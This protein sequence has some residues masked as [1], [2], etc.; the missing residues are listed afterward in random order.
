MFKPGDRYI[1]FTKYGS[2][3]FGTVKHVHEVNIID[4]ENRVVY[5]SV[6]IIT[7]KNNCLELDGSDG[8]IYRIVKDLSDDDVKAL[9]M[10]GHRHGSIESIT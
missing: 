1:H 2:V 8:R 3:D 6:S 4:T 9:K 10:I 7:D 5:V